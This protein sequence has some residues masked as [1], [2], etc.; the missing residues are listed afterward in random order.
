TGRDRVLLLVARVSKCRRARVGPSRRRR[1]ERGRNSTAQS[2]E[3]RHREHDPEPPRTNP[4]PLPVSSLH[5]HS[6]FSSRCRTLSPKLPFM[7]GDQA[8]TA[9]PPDPPPPHRAAP[10]PP[11]SRRRSASR[12][13]EPPFLPR[14]LQKRNRS[15]RTKSLPKLAQC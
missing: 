9:A 10:Q 6:S 1:H 8:S 11:R 7:E 5:H 13:G 14:R 12:L 2:A 15:R 3:R 4:C